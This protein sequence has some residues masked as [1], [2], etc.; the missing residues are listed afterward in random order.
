MICSQGDVLDEVSGD[1]GGFGGHESGACGEHMEVSALEEVSKVLDGQINSQ[2][3]PIKGAVACLRRG[4]LGKEG[5]GSPHSIDVLLEYRSYCYV[6]SIRRERG[7]CVCLG[8][9]KKGGTCQSFFRGVEG[10]YGW[11]RPGQGLRL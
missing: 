1:H 4:H 10:G 7:W 2:Q 9:G 5:N 11:V 6:R 8:V 3:F